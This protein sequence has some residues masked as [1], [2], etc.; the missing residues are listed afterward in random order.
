M[1]LMRH[2]LGVTAAIMLL[3]QQKG[4]APQLPLGAITQPMQPAK[5]LHAVAHSAVVFVVRLK[6]VRSL[7]MLSCTRERVGWQQ[8][9]TQCCLAS[10]KS[11]SLAASDTRHSHVTL[12]PVSCGGGSR[13]SDR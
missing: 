1:P 2:G 8:S 6:L 12:R 5:L 3:S 11:R 7:F 10:G 9:L 13:S 4:C